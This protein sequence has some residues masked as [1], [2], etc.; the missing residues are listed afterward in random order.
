MLMKN[1]HQLLEIPQSSISL[2]LIAVLLEWWGVIP[3]EIVENGLF[4]SEWSVT[5]NS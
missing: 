4:A 3:T 2:L 5:E 1:T